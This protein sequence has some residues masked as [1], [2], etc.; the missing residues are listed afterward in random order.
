MNVT[1]QDMLKAGVHF[2]HRTRFWNPKMAPYIYGSRERIH[3]I[4]L[5]KTAEQLK[6]AL[7]FVRKL[8]A[9]KGKVIFVGTKRACQ[10][11]VKEQASRC[12]MPYINKRWLGGMMTNYKTIRRSVRKLKEI[13]KLIGDEARSESYTKKEL[14]N[15]QRQLNKMEESL[16]GIKDMAGLPDALF[17]IDVKSEKIAIQEA[18]RLGIPVIAVVDT[19]CTP[20]GV[21]YII[22]GNDDAIKAVKLYTE[23][24]ADAVLEGAAKL[25]QSEQAIEQNNVSNTEAESKDSAKK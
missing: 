6:E 1:V 7:N 4:D 10:E 14:L 8:V 5:D 15:M 25:E 24:M 20:D 21:D 9:N 11:T 2:G 18:N 16:G 12:G 3:I 23:A 13:E 17:V 19:N 22:P